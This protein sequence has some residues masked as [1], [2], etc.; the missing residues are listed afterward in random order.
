[1]PVASR[2]EVLLLSD[3]PSEAAGVPE[4]VP[5]LLRVPVDGPLWRPLH[6]L[7]GHELV[8]AVAVGV[9]RAQHVQRGTENLIRE[10][11]ELGEI[12]A[13]I[14]AITLISAQSYE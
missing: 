4:D 9:G 1:M 10:R 3:G 5:V 14:D 7:P 12:G 8:L 11:G 13:L 6:K 2:G